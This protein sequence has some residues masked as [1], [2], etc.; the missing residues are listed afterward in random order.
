[1]VSALNPKQSCQLMDA[2]F[3][4]HSICYN[5][6]LQ[7]PCTSERQPS[8]ATTMKKLVS[9]FIANNANRE[10]LPKLLGMSRFSP[11]SQKGDGDNITDIR[12]WNVVRA[13]GTESH[14]IPAHRAICID[15][16]IH[17]N[18]YVW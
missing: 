1:M 9:S 14:P 2:N 6:A 12:V 8:Y 15:E 17:N 5:I 10:A 13:H 4:L 11:P 16:S 18:G 7:G 3:G